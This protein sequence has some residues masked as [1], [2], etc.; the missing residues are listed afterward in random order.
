MCRGRWRTIE[1]VFGGSGFRVGRGWPGV[2]GHFAHNAVLVDVIR[3]QQTEC[4]SASSPSKVQDLGFRV[5]G[6]G[7]IECRVLGRVRGPGV[8]VQGLIRVQGLRFRVQGLGFRVQGLGFRV[9]GLGFRVQGLGFRGLGF[10]VQGL[11]FSVR[12]QSW[13]RTNGDGMKVQGS[14]I[15]VQ[16]SG[17]R[18]QGLGSRVQGLGFRV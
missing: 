11:E 12:L 8:T 1:K 6:L 2:S 9:Q 10:R 15:R 7:F 16:G 18:V 14:G 4:Q 5:Y 13:K 17:F 3:I